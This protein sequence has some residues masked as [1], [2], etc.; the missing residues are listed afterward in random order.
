MV[1]ANQS[2]VRRYITLAPWRER[3][4]WGRLAAE[5]S[6]ADLG[7]ELDRIRTRSRRTIRGISAEPRPPP[8]AKWTIS[9]PLHPARLDVAA[10]ISRIGPVI[11]ASLIGR[12]SFA[13]DLPLSPLVVVVVVVVV[14]IIVL[15]GI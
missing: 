4:A 14:I 2:R 12:S 10:R 11:G 9:Q 5:S 6:R 8:A 15:I 1:M 7:L 3:R 13:I